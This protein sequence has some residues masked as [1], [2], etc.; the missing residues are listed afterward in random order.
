MPENEH[1]L[2]SACGHMSCPH[3][4]AELQTARRGVATL[5]RLLLEL[6]RYGLADH[7][8][9]KKTITEARDVAQL[10]PTVED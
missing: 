10:P 2:C 1:V 7:P 9:M 4:A 6:D 8:W 3:L 5:R